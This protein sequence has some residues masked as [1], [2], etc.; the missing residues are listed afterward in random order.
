MA[1]DVLDRTSEWFQQTA[2]NFPASAM[3]S[4][5]IHSLN[6]LKRTLQYFKFLEGPTGT[7]NSFKPPLLF[8]H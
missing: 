1:Y 5:S 8:N 2:E 4:V 7:I 6:F 3:V